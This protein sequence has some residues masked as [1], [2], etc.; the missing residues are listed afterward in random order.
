MR[1]R[2]RPLPLKQSP[3]SVPLMHCSAW[4]CPPSPLQVFTRAPVPATCGKGSLCRVWLCG[5][6][7]VNGKELTK[8]EAREKG[9]V[10]ISTYITYVKAA[11][12]LLLVAL[13]LS[14]FGLASAADK[15]SQVREGWGTLE[16]PPSYNYSSIS[17]GWS[18]VCG[19]VCSGGSVTGQRTRPSP[20][21]HSHSTW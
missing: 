11:Q 19:V 20:A 3:P 1:R 12:S 6:S 14:S 9:S 13:M 17:L 16:W 4:P 10:P 18:C 7:V 8:S 21:T 2:K 15:I 5:V